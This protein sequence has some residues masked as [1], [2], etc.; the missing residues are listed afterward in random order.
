MH[1]KLYLANFLALAG[2]GKGM[3]KSWRKLHYQARFSISL[4]YMRVSIGDE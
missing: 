1:H 2:E 4:K 3:G